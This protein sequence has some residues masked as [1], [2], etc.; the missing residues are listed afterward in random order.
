MDMHLEFGEMVHPSRGEGEQERGPDRVSFAVAGKPG[1]PAMGLATIGFYQ[2]VNTKRQDNPSIAMDS[3]ASDAD[4]AVN[5]LAE[6]VCVP[7]VPGVLVNHVL[8]HH[9]QRHVVIPPRLVGDHIERLGGQL[10]PAGML[11]L[12]LPGGERFQPGRPTRVVRDLEVALVR[13]TRPMSSALMVRRNQ[14]RSTS[15]MCRTDPAETAS[16]RHGLLAQLV[17]GEPIAFHGEGGPMKLQEGTQHL[18]FA[19]DRGWANT[20]GGQG[21]SFRWWRLVR[22]RRGDRRRDSHSTDSGRPRHL[23]C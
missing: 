9:P 19:G 12:G 20:F 3:C 6:E 11:D 17:I 18:A 16:R 21:T 8:H 1:E 14:T 15:A 4:D 10:D 13:H 22:Y 7:A 5:S 2:R 23:P